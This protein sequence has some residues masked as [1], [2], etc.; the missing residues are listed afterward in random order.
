[1][2][3]LAGTIAACRVSHTSIA[4]YKH[5]AV[6]WWDYLESNSAFGRLS[7]DIIAIIDLELHYISPFHL[8][9]FPKTH[10]SKPQRNNVDWCE[11][12]GCQIDA[13]GSRRHDTT[14]RSLD[15]TQDTCRSSGYE[16][17][18]HTTPT[19]SIARSHTARQRPSVIK[20]PSVGGHVI[21]KNK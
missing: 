9:P 14:K 7:L 4:A 20:G 8:L 3:P 17:V 11:K 21:T 18:R 12:I 2:G 1:M 6:S 13:I 15:R 16:S 19:P 5:R 10:G